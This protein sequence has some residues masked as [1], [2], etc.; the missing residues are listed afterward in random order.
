MPPPPSNS[1]QSTT[2][3]HPRLTL[4]VPPTPSLKYKQ[5]TGKVLAEA[6]G[7]VWNSRISKSEDPGVFPAPLVFDGDELFCDPK[8]PGQKLRDWLDLDSRN[9]VTPEKN[10][11]YVAAPPKVDPE[12]EFIGT[13]TRPLRYGPGNQS[14]RPDSSEPFPPETGNIMTYLSAFYH[15]FHLKAFPSP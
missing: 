6:T 3:T 7:Q 13:W 12:A 8:Q 11:I 10:I 1:L 4:S 15:P 5:P 2:C 9:D 14:R